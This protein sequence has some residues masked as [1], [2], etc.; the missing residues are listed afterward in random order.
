MHLP[1]TKAEKLAKTQR[2]EAGLRMD[3]TVTVAL[4]E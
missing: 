4:G 3:E 2:M 1:K